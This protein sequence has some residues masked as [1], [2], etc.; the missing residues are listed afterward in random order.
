MTPLFGT[1]GIRGP[2]N[3]QPMTAEIALRLGQAAGAYFTRGGHRHRV[4][5]AKDTRLSGYM[6]EAALEAGFTSAGMDVVLVGPM[7]TPSV[8][9]LVRSLRADLGVMIS[10]SHNPYTDNGIKLFGPD[11]QKLSDATEQE[12]E[13]RVHANAPQLA[14]SAALGRAMWLADAPG[15]YIEFAKNTF[16]KSLTLEGLRIAVDCANGAAYHI[17]PLILRELGADV[18]AMHT[19]PNGMNINEAC[20]STA[21]QSLQARVVAE[22]ADLGIAL[23]GDADRVILV[24]H[25]GALVDG[26]QMLA[27][28]ALDWQR[29][30][31]LSKQAVVGTVMTNLGLERALNAHQL[32][33]IRTQVG[34][35]YVAQTMREQGINV[36]GEPSGH[37]IFSDF[38]TTGDGMVAALQVLA[39]AREQGKSVRDCAMI[40]APLPQELRNLPLNN[41]LNM[42]VLE[43]AIAQAQAQLNS[44]GRV[45]VRASGTENV[46]RVMIEC[47]DAALLRTVMDALCTRL[48]QQLAHA[49]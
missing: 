33:L 8:P 9:M 39:A 47:E 30:G 5:I 20:G 22:K 28:I 3:T 45:L 26:D 6:I 29:R 16:P 19:A 31:L 21:P 2:A 12:I 7:P 43:P 48:T 42:Q 49:A 13:R 32:E 38:S 15:R 27:L 41:P 18:I 1:D 14:A 24:D 34:D 11:G 25:T 36:G 17:A 44:K 40:Y 35:R 23:D 46:L 10:A 37:L 4:V